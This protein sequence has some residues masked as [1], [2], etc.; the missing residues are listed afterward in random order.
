MPI[1][2]IDEYR[3]KHPRYNHMSDEGLSRFLYGKYGRD[4]GMSY[5]DFDS[6][7]RGP[8]FSH[9]PK[10]MQYAEKAARLVG[11]M[12]YAGAE[13][14][15]QTMFYKPVGALLGMASPK[16][17]KWWAQKFIDPMQQ[18]LQFRQEWLERSKEDS[19]FLGKA[20]LDLAAGAGS[21][22]PT[23]AGD[24]MTGGAT[25]A[26]SLGSI[27]SKATGMLSRLPA[28]A[29]GMGVRKAVEGSFQG[30]EEGG[31]LESS[32]GAIKGLGQG[33]AEGTLM[34]RVGS[35]G[36]GLQGPKGFL[37]RLGYQMPGQA[38]V[39]T[40]LGASE[41]IGHEGRLPTLDE[42][43]Q[44]ATSGAAMGILFATYP[45]PFELVSKTGRHLVKNATQK[46]ALL[47]KNM[48]EKYGAENLENA[49]ITD[50][51]IKLNFGSKQ[52]EVVFTGKPYPGVSEF[53]PEKGA[54]VSTTHKGKPLSDVRGGKIENPESTEMPGRT[55]RPEPSH[56]G[57]PT[58]LPTGLQP[59]ET[60]PQPTVTPPLRPPWSPDTEMDPRGP[61][62]TVGQPA[63]QAPKPAKL[64]TEIRDR[65]LPSMEEFRTAVQKKYGD[66]SGQMRLFQTPRELNASGESAASL[67]A[68]RRLEGEKAKG[69]NVYKI[70][71]RKPG[72]IIPLPPTV[73]RVDTF[74]QPYEI[75]VQK[76]VGVDPYTI[77]SQ[78][79]KVA[80]PHARALLDRLV[81][82]KRLFQEA[83]LPPEG[84]DDAAT[85]LDMFLP[86]ARPEDYPII[87]GRDGFADIL[88]RTYG[89]TRG[90]LEAQ[91]TIFDAM[92]EFWVDHHRANG[93]EMTLDDWYKSTF[94]G[95]RKIAGAAQVEGMPRGAVDIMKDGR[96]VLYA[97]KSPD[98]STAI[99][100]PFHVA[101]EQLM[102]IDPMGAKV[103]ESAYG[104]TAG[105]WS[106]SQNE[107]AA[108]DF[109]RFLI[110]GE[111]TNPAV[112]GVFN[113]IKRWMLKIYSKATGM[114]VEVNPEVAKVFDRWLG[115]ELETNTHSDRIIEFTRE[116]G[117]ATYN[118]A[119]GRN[120]F[121]DKKI[122]VGVFPDKTEHI[123]G[124]LTRE[125]VTSFIE[126]NKEIFQDERF[127]VGTW[128]NSDTGMTELD[129]SV[130]VPEEWKA[131]ALAKQFNQKGTFGLGDERY[132]PTGGTGEGEAASL[133]AVLAYLNELDRD[134]PVY[135]VRYMRDSNL[136]ELDP[137]NPNHRTDI[138]GEER[139]RLEDDPEVPNRLHYYVEGGEAEPNIAQL[140]F[141]YRT[142]I[143]ASKLYPVEADPLNLVE[144]ARRFEGG[145]FDWN[146]AEAIMK[147]EG[148]WGYQVPGGRW[149]ST[150]V[151]MEQLPAK[152]M[153]S[154]LAVKA[155]DDMGIDISKSSIKDL[156]PDAIKLVGEMFDVVDL[157][158]ITDPVEIPFEN[159]SIMVPG[160]L[161]G[162]FTWLDL[163][164]LKSQGY[165]PNLIP[166]HIHARLQEKMALT[167]MP[168]PGDSMQVFNNVMFGMMSQNAA[169]TPNEFAYARIRAKNMDEIQ[170]LADYAE[171]LSDF[172]TEKERRELNHKIRRDFNLDKLKAGGIGYPGTI[173]M[174][175]IADFARL[176]LKD[177]EF[178]NK[179]D[180]EGWIEF[181][182]RIGS[183]VGGIKTKL[184]AFGGV[185]QDPLS[186]AIGAADRHII[187]RT[188][189]S[190]FPT[191][192]TQAV[193]NKEIIDAWNEGKHILEGDS[194]I[195]VKINYKDGFETILKTRGGTNF[196]AT[197]MSK[198]F[199]PKEVKFRLSSGEINPEV[200]EHLKNV[201]WIEEPD[202]VMPTS[203]AYLAAIE[204]IESS[205]V[206]RGL[207][208]FANQWMEWDRERSRLEPHEI[209]F[210]G[211]YKLPKQPT[212]DALLARG[213]HKE[214]GYLAARG[215]TRPMQADLFNTPWQRML[216][217]QIGE[218]K[219]WAK[220]SNFKKWFGRSVVAEGDLPKIVYHGTDR[221]FIAFGQGD[222]GF[223]LGTADQAHQFV[224][225]WK[226][227]GPAKKNQALT[228]ITGEADPLAGIKGQKAESLDFLKEGANI[229][230]VY[231]KLENPV[232]LRD[233]GNWDNPWAVTKELARKGYIPE[234]EA[235]DL[236]FVVNDIFESLPGDVPLSERIY[237]SFEP[238]RK[239]LEKKGYDGIVY[240]NAAEGPGDS[241]IA[242][243]PEQI[244]S[245]F[246]KG[247]WDSMSKNMM[248]QEAMPMGPP[249][250]V[251]QL[252]KKNPEEIEARL[253][254]ELDKL[255]LDEFQH[256]Y[257]EGKVG[258][259]VVMDY[260]KE[261]G[262]S[263]RQAR[264]FLFADL[265]RYKGVYDAIV[266]GARKLSPEEKFDSVFESERLFQ[267]AKESPKEKR[268]MAMGKAHMQK[269]LPEAPPPSA[270]KSL[271]QKYSD[272]IDTH[273]G[274]KLLKEKLIP[275][276]EKVPYKIGEGLT[277][278]L[279][280][281]YRGSLKDAPEYMR[282]MDEM[283]HYQAMGAEYAVN[284][285]NRLMALGEHEQLMVSDALRGA[286]KTE[287][288]PD[289]LRGVTA[290]AQQMLVNL[291]RNAVEVGLLSEEV[292]FK[293]YGKYF[294][295]LYTSKEY[296]TLVARFGAKRPDRMDMS[297]FMKRKDIPEE[298]RK[299]MG[300]ILTP[301]YPVAKA[302]SQLTHDIEMAKFFKGVGQNPE[303]AVPQEIQWRKGKSGQWKEHI[304]ELPE[305]VVDQLKAKGFKQ[306]TNSRKLGALKGAWVHEEIY[307]DFT[308][309]I[310][311]DGTP[312]R[313]WKRS[314]GAWKFGKV[315]LSPK[316]HM[317]NCFS[318]S[319]LAHLGGMPLYDQPHYLSRAWNEMKNPGEFWRQA[320][321]SGLL[322]AT[323]TK[324]E[325]EA[326]FDN[327]NFQ[328]K[329]PKASALGSL[330]V[331]GKVLSKLK[332]GATSA[333]R[334]Y[335]FE[336][337]WFKLAKMMHN[338]EKR[339]MDA[340]TAS[341]DAEK[342]LFNYSKLTR[343]QEKYRS[344]PLG[345]PFATF[346]FKA[347]PRV[348][349]ALI[350]TPW[351]FALPLAMMKGVESMAKVLF[352][353]T[354]EEE[355]AKKEMRPDWMQGGL[356]FL[357]NFIRFPITDNHNREYYLNLTYMMPWGD[358][359]E[360]GGA[361]GIPGALMPFT[362][363][364][365]K[366]PVQQIA[367]FDTYWQQPIVPEAETA[368]LGK[369]EQLAVGG[370]ERLG[371]LAQTMAPS[372]V[373]DIGK[374]KDLFSGKPDYKGRTRSGVSVA[375][376]TL[377]G[378]KTYP[379]DYLEQ[380][381]RQVM[382]LHPKSGFQ[383]REIKSKIKSA[384]RKRAAIEDLGKN[385]DYYDKK[386][387]AYYKQLQGLAD[388]VIKVSE[389]F[390]KTGI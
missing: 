256:I 65:K 176:F 76:G 281:D 306:L 26:A 376:D 169:L 192:K 305:E 333:A 71:V 143:P 144:R 53:V 277:K 178:F 216:Y 380:F 246:N 2:T 167:M 300:E 344:H 229:K 132:M 218:L 262:M 228:I 340:Q 276:L 350:K 17:Y 155:L 343:F 28:F 337:Q 153:A 81:E 267:A 323:W 175:R 105:R 287:S 164:W 16:A 92:G 286:V 282:E 30:A 11:G 238:I 365:T 133:E 29:T 56:T 357:P 288:L 338:M 62:G 317:R 258:A 125:Q 227:S 79:D 366:E 94:A 307:K 331:A 77:I 211:L 388:Q 318:N 57:E 177:P 390:G 207:G 193:F 309:L 7:F 173:D 88:M 96:A 259:K 141:K 339:G 292:F 190:I 358:I 284:V 269:L 165:N 204:A 231:L 299:E 118:V 373:M 162:K 40:G 235:T 197:Y 241:Y 52:T 6:S 195:R 285:G 97:L 78:G 254:V 112:K 180:T 270:N 171:Q 51:G 382:K 98:F 206:E 151:M 145:P 265:A 274:D 356:P 23:I 108:K 330:E 297:R 223:H 266:E 212:A 360:A 68:Q 202:K 185:W 244:K 272:L 59:G 156:N 159:G 22:V 49:E 142:E 225:D 186:A 236:G 41:M 174:T 55:L 106:D 100:E 111:V 103:L 375:L 82:S 293:N 247:T 369:L 303:W 104:V 314:L 251:R 139:K 47:L 313:V 58:P 137:D 45:T 134:V 295:R 39:A 24:V 129:I 252:V 32:L 210:P 255:G 20:G 113:K 310:K 315:I 232:K 196:F 381:E 107:W 116:K 4:K 117:G 364:F 42:V 74:A 249:E 130:A 240:S 14:F 85:F 127:N 237:Q 291:G 233:V 73:D 370:K 189:N 122:A 8:Q 353:D 9:D 89:P 64:K 271:L 389:T 188:V 242:F 311:V 308:D 119:T 182:E 34:H 67:E 48:I 187:R 179:K 322:D 328:M 351:R 326:L 166:E 335:E 95:G 102:S 90:Q 149:E 12:A 184:A 243:R 203:D 140:P 135:L 200:P 387:E 168:E 191:K 15:G 260:A 163:L 312:E 27:G 368:G 25:E 123:R 205:A 37:T 298:I 283:R 121:G 268:I 183:Q 80:R 136:N 342:W 99:H 66:E 289:H 280:R 215:E 234:A 157:G 19:G 361:F 160:G 320:K 152:E 219:E 13:E 50:T 194:K 316:T 150:V 349:E 371:H 199:L 70:D 44:M 336:E 110:T 217:Y 290:E 325:L 332:R 131:T 75:V 91:L 220:T 172:P 61:A 263:A 158:P 248:Y 170:G 275:L 386:I 278:A 124:E 230:P 355:E 209:M 264:D 359:G 213:A 147:E 296:D 83:E 93:K 5:E 36:Q 128:K 321:L 327:V 198:F 3:E 63:L 114:N 363:P 352:E 101:K 214:A 146:M 245:V 154:H 294:P 138:K 38:T 31:L 329:Q 226:K 43:S 72:E 181:T 126:K 257:S 384:L 87:P 161:Q 18:D 377:A 239:V 372:A 69:Q 84:S 253:R 304:K 301:G 348:A 385:T 379:V 367:N 115:S 319:I 273:L 46:D 35:L 378:V 222:I 302:I 86:K 383:A 354:K 1:L 374:F 120:L 345:A 250:D 279:N 54:K 21:L 221:D 148:Y 334:A 109:E 224:L 10:K 201:D 261:K 362:Q 324:G 60:V 208:V 341:K 347:L 346:T 33:L